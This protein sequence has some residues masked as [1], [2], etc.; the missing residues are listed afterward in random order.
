[1]QRLGAGVWT[2]DQRSSWDALANH[3]LYLV[4]VYAPAGAVVPLAPVVQVYAGADGGF[5]LT[6]DDGETTGYQSGAARRT[7][8]TWSD[9][10]RS[11]KWSTTS[12]DKDIG[13]G[14]AVTF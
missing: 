11:L 10:T 3:P 5:V 13:T 7:T 1:M 9:A 4:A 8:F 6:E 14:G 2:G 12:V